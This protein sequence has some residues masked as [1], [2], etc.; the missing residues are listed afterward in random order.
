MNPVAQRSRKSESFRHLENAHVSEDVQLLCNTVVA[1]EEDVGKRPGM[2]IFS[3]GNR[4]DRAAAVS[5][6]AEPFSFLEFLAS[7]LSTFWCRF[8]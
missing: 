5:S 6:M 2:E 7:H 4:S 3:D 8:G 1:F